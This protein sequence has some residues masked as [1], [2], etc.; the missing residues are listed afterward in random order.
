MR[1]LIEKLGKVAITVEKDYWDKSKPYDKL[2]VVERKGTF[3]TYISRKPVPANVEITNRNYWI[4]FS[5]L[6]EDL[7]TDYNSFIARYGGILQEYAVA[8]NN[9]NELANTVYAKLPYGIIVDPDSDFIEY[10]DSNKTINIH[11]KAVNEDDHVDHR[12]RVSVNDSGVDFTVDDDSHSY[13]DYGG[14][15]FTIHVNI[16]G[17]SLIRVICDDTF[18]DGTQIRY[19]STIAVYTLYPSYL[20]FANFRVSG[21]LM[22]EEYIN[23]LNLTNYKIAAGKDIS[24]RYIRTH[25]V[26]EGGA[27]LVLLYPQGTIVKD[28]KINGIEVLK[29]VQGVPLLGTMTYNET[30]YKLFISRSS[31][32]PGVEYPVVINSEYEERGDVLEDILNQLT[33]LPNPDEEDITLDINT[34]KYKFKDKVYNAEIHSGLGRKYLRKNTKRACYPFDGFVANVP[35]TKGLFDQ[36]V[37]LS[38]RRTIGRVIPQAEEQLENVATSEISEQLT[39]ITYTAPDAIFYDAYKKIFVGGVNLDV[40]SGSYKYYGDTWRSCQGIYFPMNTDT[41]FYRR[42]TDNYYRF[43]GRELVEYFGT[44]VSEINVLTQAMINEINTIYIIQYDYDLKGATIYL[45]EN[46]VLDFE[47]GSFHNGVVIGNNTKVV[48]N[49]ILENISL[50]GS[51]SDRVYAPNRPSNPYIGQTMLLD[52]GNKRINET[53]YVPAWWTGDMWIDA[54]GNQI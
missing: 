46:C 2:T 38:G 12:W 21:Y 40:T 26:S 24:G 53:I 27:K 16:R 9:I 3:G 34:N 23:S 25:N 37:T 44:V 5:S 35:I 22:I 39:H 17:E 11:V 52:I 29:Q 28:I 41:I 50:Q 20:F 10:N 45:P 49:P 33:Y 14:N 43:N 48:G 36:I 51:W 54:N 7:I 1:T 6:R 47:G 13:D 8:I 18:P 4:P 30:D 19:A 31:Y 15:D 42:D 32:I